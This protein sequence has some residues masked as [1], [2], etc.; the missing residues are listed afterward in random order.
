MAGM[1]KKPGQVLSK[2]YSPRKHHM[3]EMNKDQIIEARKNQ[4]KGD[5]R[6]PGFYSFNPELQKEKDDG[7]Q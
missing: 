4:G 7:C 6:R 1:I 3:A 2:E 5:D